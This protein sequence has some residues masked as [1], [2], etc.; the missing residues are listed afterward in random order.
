MRRGT[1]TSAGSLGWWPK[2]A[3]PRESQ[4]DPTTK[5]SSKLTCTKWD[6]KTRNPSQNSKTPQQTN[7]DKT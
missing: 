6:N 4:E 1:I 2:P 5:V 7:T 3:I